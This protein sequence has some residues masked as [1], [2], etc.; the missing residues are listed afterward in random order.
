MAE[1]QKVTRTEIYTET[2]EVP[3]GYRL[4]LN[5]RE[6]ATIIALWANVSGSMENSPRGDFH[7][8]ATALLEAGAEHFRD[9]EEFNLLVGAEGTHFKSRTG[10]RT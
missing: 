6:A 9:S 3:D 4:Y 10:A 1:A 8:V 5:E 2:R 7:S